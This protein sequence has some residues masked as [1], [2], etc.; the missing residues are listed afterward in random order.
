MATWGQA[1]GKTLLQM[2]PDVQ[3]KMQTNFEDRRNADVMREIARIALMTDPA[4]QQAEIQRM[5]TDPNT[6]REIMQYLPKVAEASSAG[7]RGQQASRALAKGVGFTG[8]TTGLDAQTILAMQQHNLL[9]DRAL[10]E[11]KAGEITRAREE[12]TWSQRQEAQK[13]LNSEEGRRTAELASSTVRDDRTGSVVPAPGASAAQ[14]LYTQKWHEAG[15]TGNPPFQEPHYFAPQSGGGTRDTTTAKLVAWLKAKN[16]V[17]E[18][19]GMTDEQ[20]AAALAEID[21][22]FGM[23]TPPPPEDTPESTYEKVLSSQGGD[24]EK[25]ITI[26]DRIAA[27]PSANA[28]QK[29]N[30]KRAAMIGRG[31][32]GTRIR[33]GS[34]ARTR[35]TLPPPSAEESELLAAEAEL[36]AIQNSRPSVSLSD[37]SGVTDANTPA[38]RNWVQ[39]VEVAR[40]KVA[41]LKEKKRLADINRRFGSQ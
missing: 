3:K 10:A 27:D 17:Y 29:Q 7:I 18:N 35:Q 5:M 14:I 6:P 1:F 20:K 13:W 36:K 30:A 40:Q 24:V 2:A 22:A 31:V 37:L 41:Q 39:R 15:Y 38:Y 33:Q 26:L 9:R 4:Q 19:L 23:T 11:E 28:Q 12:A 21:R 16:D 32:I 8:D 25:A 34:G